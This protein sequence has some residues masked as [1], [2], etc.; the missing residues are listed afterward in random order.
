MLIAGDTA[1]IC[2][3]LSMWKTGALLSPKLTFVA[4]LKLVPVIITFVPPVI[5]PKFGLTA[6]T[7]GNGNILVLYVNACGNVID[8][9]SV[10]VNNTSTVPSGCGGTNNCTS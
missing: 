4:S 6:F 7:F 1:V 5:G 9:P 3:L 8:K 10:L 2:V